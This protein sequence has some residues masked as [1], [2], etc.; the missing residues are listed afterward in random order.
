M[1]F[2]FPLD[3]SGFMRVR[4]ARLMAGTRPLHRLI[5]PS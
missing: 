1:E 5:S 3:F 2:D 4:V